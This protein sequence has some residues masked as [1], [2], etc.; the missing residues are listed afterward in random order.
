L[1]KSILNRFPFPITVTVMQLAMGSLFFL[2]GSKSGTHSLLSQRIKQRHLVR[3]AYTSLFHAAGVLASHASTLTSP[4]IAHVMVWKSGQPLVSTLLSVSLGTSATC[5]LLPASLSYSGIMLAASKATMI[6]LAWSTLSNLAFAARGE[7]ISS[8][9]PPRRFGGGQNLFWCLSMASLVWL[10]PLAR[11]LEPSAPIGEFWQPLA[12]SGALFYLTNSLAFSSLKQARNETKTPWTALRP[13]LPKV[14][15]CI[16]L[17][18][19]P[20]SPSVFVCLLAFA[21]QW[22]YQYI[23]AERKGRADSDECPLETI[24]ESLKAI[25]WASSSSLAGSGRSNRSLVAA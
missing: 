8:R 19:Q 4:S 13:I 17:V 16:V 3:I 1:N 5:L 24:R 14:V 18:Y 7:A 23:K 11:F 20:S 25:Q 22:R 6:G 9:L 21:G 2:S 10:V 15:T 12:L